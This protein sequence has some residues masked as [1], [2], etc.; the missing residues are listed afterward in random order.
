MDSFEN[1]SLTSPPARGQIGRLVGNMASMLSS[2]TITRV[3][4]FLL[5]VLVGR[6]LGTQSFGRISLALTLLATFQVFST[7]GLKML[8]VRE[9]ASDRARTEEYLVNGSLVVAVFSLLSLGCLLLLSFLLSY[10][11]ATS[12]IILLF[13]LGLLPFS[14]S[15]VCEA[16]F[17]AHERMGYILVVN[18]PRNLLLIGAT[19]WLLSVGH[20]L[21]S[22]GIL[23]LLLNF[24][25][26]GME[27]WIILRHIARP[28]RLPGVAGA[29]AMTR[30]SIPFMGFQSIVAITT[31]SIYVILSI[32]V[33][34]AEVGLFNAATQV[35]TPVVLIYDSVVVAGY[36]VLCQR[37]R[38]N[39]QALKRMSDRL[40]ELVVSIALPAMIGLFFLGKKAL[41]LIYANGDFARAGN[42]LRI[43]AGSVVLSALSAVL[44]RILL[45]SL[46]ERA[47]LRIVSIR[48]LANLISGLLLTKVFGL[49]GAAISFMLISIFDTA[50]HFYQ[51]AR[52]YPNAL[53]WHR[54]WKTALA[55]SGMTL[56]ILATPSWGVIAEAIV[57]GMIYALLWLGFS[58]WSAGSVRQL[59]A[60]YFGI[61]ST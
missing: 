31:S 51:V 48:F 33:N 35:I 55:T 16:I 9:V 49:L 7:A 29:L 47:L 5:Y 57:G 4:T 13:G 61:S 59:R 34:E 30:A 40:L 6:Y 32:F 38:M 37:F 43:M 18:I 21:R 56:F 45:A 50:L 44:A 53:P 36:P 20:G 1:A 42:L 54:L 23:I 28:K 24:L 14:L 52:L 11:P 2:D 8:I 3:T 12:E 46:H 27:W 41:L 58:I 26:L 17:Q 39:L 10:S 15:T 19:L 25:V 22:I 60:E